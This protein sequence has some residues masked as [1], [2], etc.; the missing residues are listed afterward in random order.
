MSIVKSRQQQIMDVAVDLLADKGIQNLTMKHLSAQIG[1]SEAAIYRYF[2]SKQDILFAL[3]D[4]YEKRTRQK[5]VWIENN[6]QNPLQKMEA[7]LLDR[8]QICQDTPNLAKVVFAE[9]YFQHN[10]KLANKMT[11]MMQEHG[12]FL[13]SLLLQCQ[14][15]KIFR[16]DIDA[17]VLFRLIIGPLRLLIKQWTLRPSRFSLK[18]EGIH[19]WE[20][21]KRL[22]MNPEHV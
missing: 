8:Y 2:E 4:S 11:H 9:E 1:I 3:L 13:G 12:R 17:E 10:E 14:Q 15:E 22:L 7:F 20:S 21:Q 6:L 18:D 16:S 5:I 19:L